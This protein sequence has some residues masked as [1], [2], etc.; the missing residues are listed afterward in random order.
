MQTSFTSQY[1]SS[2]R[3]DGTQWH[4]DDV[5]SAKRRRLNAASTDPVEM[6][7]SEQLWASP[8]AWDPN[9]LSYIV[10]TGSFQSDS[11]VTGNMNDWRYADDTQSDWFPQEYI[12][13]G[14]N[15]VDPEQQYPHLGHNQALTCNQQHRWPQNPTDSCK[16]KYCLS[17]RLSD[18]N[19][20]QTQERPRLR[21]FIHSIRKTTG[22][23][24]CLVIPQANR[25]LT[26]SRMVSFNF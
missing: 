8:F 18:I 14:R 2:G 24:V 22:H 3:C 16:L 17:S 11:C 13:D 5:A 1:P 21:C 10:D 19:V 6:Q 7:P 20:K 23:I 12:D 15:N 25:S 9:D 26:G 4:E